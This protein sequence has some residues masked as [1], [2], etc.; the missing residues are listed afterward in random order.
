MAQRERV[1]LTILPQIR[2]NVKGLG[3]LRRFDSILLL[4][5]ETQLAGPHADLVSRAQ[6]S[7]PDSLPVD[8]GTVGTAQV[9]DRE[10]GAL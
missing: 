6:C 10:D 2:P 7:L 1:L 4:R 9:D 3:I 5:P 8:K